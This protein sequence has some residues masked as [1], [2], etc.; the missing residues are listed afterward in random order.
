MTQSLAPLFSAADF[1]AAFMALMPRGKVWPRDTDSVIAQT[2]SCLAPTYA[3]QTLS[4]QELLADAF[5]SNP[6][7]LL[8]EWEETLGL[9][10]PYAGV[11]TV[12]QRQAQV[13]QKFSQPGGQTVAYYLAVIAAIGFAGATITEYTPFQANVSVANSPLYGP[14]WASAWKITAPNL[15]VAYFETNVSAANE[16]L[17]TIVGASELEFLIGQYAPAHTYPLFAVA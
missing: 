17:F 10:N 13:L 16:A 8:P 14:T 5:P 15:S 11:Q 3:R 6:V 4:L 1:T 2:V 9:P 12:A 7:Q